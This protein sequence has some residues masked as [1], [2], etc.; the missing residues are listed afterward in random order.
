MK[1]QDEVVG[2]LAAFIVMLPLL[3]LS[4]GVS[5]LIALFV[6]WFL[7][8]ALG[9]NLNYDLWTIFIITIV[10]TTISSLGGK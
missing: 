4:L 9:A 6:I 5:F 10:L 3:A 2:C 7:N 8:F 1:K